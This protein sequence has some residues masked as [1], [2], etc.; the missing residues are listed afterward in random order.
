VAAL[1]GALSKL[2]AQFLKPVDVRWSHQKAG[3][4]FMT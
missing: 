2:Q 3:Y 4:S 1:S